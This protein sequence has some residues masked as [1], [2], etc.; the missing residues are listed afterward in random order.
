[1]IGGPIHLPMRA[2][3][4]PCPTQVPQDIG[5]LQANAPRGDARGF[6]RVLRERVIA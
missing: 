5:E 2:P 3:I 1:M 4:L 6:V